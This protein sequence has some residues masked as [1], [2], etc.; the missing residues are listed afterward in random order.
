MGDNRGEHSVG[1]NR[2]EH[3]VGDKVIIGV[4]TQ[5]VIIRQK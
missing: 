1:D 5:W 3:S 4:N 2:G